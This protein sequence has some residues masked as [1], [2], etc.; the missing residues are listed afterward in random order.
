MA[1]IYPMGEERAVVRECLGV[2]LT[3]TQLPSA[4][5]SVV[6]NVE[7]VC[8]IAEAVDEKKPCI[9]KNMT[10][11]GKL[12]GGNEAHVFFDVPVGVSVGEMIEK[13]AES[14]E[15][16]ERSSWVELQQE[17]YYIRCT[18]NQTTGAILVTVEFPDLHGATMGILVCA[19]GGSEERMREIASKMN[20]KVVSMCKM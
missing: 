9:S 12:N 3:T 17:V 8:K 2:L 14:T 18:N 5:R 4:A 15:N 10:V 7:T 6:I 19:C 20:A 16:M 11:R 1:D 13:P